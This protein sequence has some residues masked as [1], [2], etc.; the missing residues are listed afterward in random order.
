MER[1]ESDE[2]SQR[3]SLRRTNW[4]YVASEVFRIGDGRRDWRM[5]MAMGG[6]TCGVEGLRPK[7]TDDP[8][9]RG[10]CL[11]RVANVGVGSVLVCL[12][13]WWMSCVWDPEG[14]ID[15]KQERG[16]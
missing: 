6:D 8:R 11:T 12:L 10:G 1:G 16:G 13:Q 15:G 4:L 3:T 2:E 5:K 9:G 14:R 7:Q